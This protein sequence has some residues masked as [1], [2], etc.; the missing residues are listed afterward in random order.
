V[1]RLREQIPFLRDHLIA[2]QKVRDGY[3]QQ[4]QIGQ[5][6]LMDLLDTESELFEAKRALANAEFDHLDSQ[7]RW[8]SL[9]NRLLTTL[10]LSQ[11]HQEML[12]ESDGLETDDELLKLCDASV[13]DTRL[14]AP[15]NVVYAPG[16]EP[17][18]LRPVNSQGG[19][20]PGWR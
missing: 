3:G 20:A 14:L 16:T 17:P 6:S 1:A 9:S 11:P 8:L 13:S 19:V 7:Y 15:V 10:E 4:F 12:E 18:T 5:R 2:T